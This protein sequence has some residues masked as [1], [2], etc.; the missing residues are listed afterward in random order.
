MQYRLSEFFPRGVITVADQCAKAS[1]NK[2]MSTKQALIWL[3]F[4]VRDLSNSSNIPVALLGI[5]FVN[6]VI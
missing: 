3:I 2:K 1:E 5:A 6:G 4:F